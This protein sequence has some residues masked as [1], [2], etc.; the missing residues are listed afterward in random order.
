MSVSFPSANIQMLGDLTMINQS[1]ECNFVVLVQSEI[2]QSVLYSMAKSQVQP[3]I[4]NYENVSDC[5]N[6]IHQALSPKF[7]ERTL[8]GDRM[9]DLI[10]VLDFDRAN[11]SND[12]F[13]IAK[14]LEPEY[15]IT[16]E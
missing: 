7:T 16:V 6:N 13:Q 10:V 9:V 11:H 1:G 3:Y 12:L 15:I 4:F 8:F 14:Y 2:I 5:L